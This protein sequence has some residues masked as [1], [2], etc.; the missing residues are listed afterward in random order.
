VRANLAKDVKEA[1][2]H[3]KKNPEKKES[4]SAAL[5]GATATFPKADMGDDLLRVLMKVMFS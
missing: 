1:I 2:D 4:D 3:L 5:Y